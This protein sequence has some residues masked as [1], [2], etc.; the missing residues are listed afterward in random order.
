REV[1]DRDSRLQSTYNELTDSP[2]AIRR[3]VSASN[4]A[5]DNWRIFLHAAPSALSGMVSVTTN[6]SICDFSMLP[7][8]GPD[9]T[10]WVQYATTSLAPRSFS[11][12]DAAHN[13]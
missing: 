6:S 8:A 10:A 13:V 3:T 2:Y 1:V 12:F 7:I 4:C 5:T 11:A 9:N